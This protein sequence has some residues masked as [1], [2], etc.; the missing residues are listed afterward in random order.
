MRLDIAYLLI[1][2]IALCLL[3][4]A[5]QTWRYHQYEARRARGHNGKPMRKP[6]WT[7]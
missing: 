6:F 3:A 4:M 7:P 5:R 1:A 2:L